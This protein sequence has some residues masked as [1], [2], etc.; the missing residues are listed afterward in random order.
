VRAEY[1]NLP[2]QIFKRSNAP[3][4]RTSRKHCEAQA[5]G[6]LSTVSDPNKEI[7]AIMGHARRI[8]GVA[9]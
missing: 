5:G 8:L 3:G 6:N 9:R 7:Y 2:A 4:S 1:P